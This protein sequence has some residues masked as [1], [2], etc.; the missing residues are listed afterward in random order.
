MV[1]WPKGKRGLPGLK[2]GAL[3]AL[4][5]TIGALAC[6]SGSSPGSGAPTPDASSSSHPDT[7]SGAPSDATAGSSDSGRD[8]AVAPGDGAVPIDSSAAPDSGQP[9]AAPGTV[10]S[11]SPAEPIHFHWQLSDAFTAAD[12][13]AGQQG[14][15]V[16]DIDGQLA[17]AA[18][19]AMI[20]A[21]GAIAIC[22]V[23]V[24]GLEQG[25]PDYAQFPASVV[26]PVVQGWPGE[27]WL[28]VTAANQGLILPLMQARFEQWCQAKGFDAVEPDNLDV[29][30]NLSGQVSE[31][32]NVA[33]DLAI[34]S[35][36][37]A[38]KLSIGLKN[39]LSDLSASNV[40][41][42]LS[43]F[44]WALVEQCYEYT[45]C[46]VYSQAGSF[47]PLGKAVFDVEYN[48]TPTCTDAAMIHMNAQKRDL[49]LVAPTTAGYAYAP[50]VP[51]SQATW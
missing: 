39:L 38:L 37:H 4:A 9:E 40:P 27:N 41:T 26:G 29:F 31:T 45:E 46:S 22:Y 5:W 1:A 48:V 50:C 17:T 21:A 13:L 32:D 15:V 36:V 3:G 49:D 33:Y 20:H 8:A 11:P 6:G 24:G 35:Q 47:L 23:D 12:L 10:W 28:L 34:A 7:D 14:A 44:D 18:D 43:S 30:S 25:R 16:Y 51:D 19:V 2:P 42:I